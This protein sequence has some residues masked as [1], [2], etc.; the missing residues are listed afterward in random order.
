MPAVDVDVEGL[1]VAVGSACEEGL[2]VEVDGFGGGGVIGGVCGGEVHE[3]ITGRGAFEHLHFGV[4]GGDVGLFGFGV[5]FDIEVEV[6]VALG[7]GLRFF[8]DFSGFVFGVFGFGL[9]GFDF[10]V[11]L[12]EFSFE[13]FVFGFELLDFGFEAVDFGLEGFDI[14]L[15]EGG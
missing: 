3:V 2:D 13:G 1:S 10:F 9:G 5:F 15:S 11:R 14:V 8:D 4:D 7:D 12:G 6:L